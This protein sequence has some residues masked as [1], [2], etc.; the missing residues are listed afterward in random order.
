MVK[1]VMLWNQLDLNYNLDSTTYQANNSNYLMGSS[2]DY[3]SLYLEGTGV[4]TH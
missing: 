1:S 4:G 3:L 2:K